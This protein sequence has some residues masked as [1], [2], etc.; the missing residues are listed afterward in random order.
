MTRR[1]DRYQRHRREDHET[2]L[3]MVRLAVLAV[4]VALARK[5]D[6]SGTTSP[7]LASAMN[8][9]FSLVAGRI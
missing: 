3:A 6:P 4:V 8:G 1:N 7:P 9:P 2:A 5:K